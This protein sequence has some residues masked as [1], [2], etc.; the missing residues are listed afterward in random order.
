VVIDGAAPAPGS[1]RLGTTSVRNPKDFLHALVRN[2]FMK[3]TTAILVALALAG[4]ATKEQ[5]HAVPL[6]S[7]VRGN[8]KMVMTDG[9]PYPAVQRQKRKWT[10]REYRKIWEKAWEQ[11]E[12]VKAHVRDGLYPYLNLGD[13]GL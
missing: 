9:S 7:G 5:Y 11:R 4:C 13:Y 10:D 2:D 12:M 6:P 8:Y 3:T 1:V